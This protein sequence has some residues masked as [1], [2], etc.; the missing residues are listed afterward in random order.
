MQFYWSPW[1]IG[2]LYRNL[3][4]ICLQRG[5]SH[6][7]IHSSANRMMELLTTY[8]RVSEVAPPYADIPGLQDRDDVPV[9]WAAAHCR[10][11]YLLTDD[12]THS[13]KSAPQ[14]SERGACRPPAT[15]SP[16]SLALRWKIV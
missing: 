11:D 1:V 13:P 2:E 10:A 6:D 12:T 9:W 4:E 5:W 7:Q 16:S 15:P 3:T 8:L 14:V